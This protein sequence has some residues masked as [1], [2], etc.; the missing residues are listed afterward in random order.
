MG[1]RMGRKMKGGFSWFG[2]EAN[3]VDVYG[4]IIPEPW[5]TKNPK[6]H[7][8][9]SFRHLHDNGKLGEEKDALAYNPMHDVDIFLRNMQEP[10]QAKLHKFEN[11][12]RYGDLPTIS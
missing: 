7:V 2:D 9:P 4:W 3:R 11:M 10:I 8:I 12:Y 6:F 5:N 1:G